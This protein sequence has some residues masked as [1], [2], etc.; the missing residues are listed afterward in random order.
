MIIAPT[1]LEV[2][3]HRPQSFPNLA[4]RNGKIEQKFL[5]IPFKRFLTELGA[6][7]KFTVLDRKSINS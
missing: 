1:G 3:Y 7:C 5:G 2:I 6:V 4:V